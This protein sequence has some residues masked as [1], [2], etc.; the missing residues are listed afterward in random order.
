[1]KALKVIV[2]ILFWTLVV[3][4]AALLALPLWI[5]P[6]AKCAVGTVGPKFTGTP[7]H[8]GEFS[9]NPY[10][11]KIEIG[12]FQVANPPDYSDTNIVDLTSLKINVAMT[13]LFSTPFYVSR[14]TSSCRY[15]ARSAW[16]A[17]FRG[18]ESRSSALV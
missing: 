16:H 3:V 2:K 14:Q 11:G 18:A 6:V 9:L 4:V 13:S 12:D 15:R 10:T 1:M 5:G 8:L 7:V 17:G